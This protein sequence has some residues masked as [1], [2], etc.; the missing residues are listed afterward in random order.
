MTGL[1]LAIAA[2]ALWAQDSGSNSA[3]WL[4]AQGSQ[5]PALEKPIWAQAA[6]A[7]LPAAAPWMQPGGGMNGAVAS[8]KPATIPLEDSWT[9]ER[10]RGDLDLVARARTGLEAEI[11]DLRSR[12]GR[13]LM[14]DP[15]TGAILP[16]HQAEATSIWVRVLDRL[17]S[18]DSVVI[19]Y[20]RFE[21]VQDAEKRTAAFLAAFSA[22]ASWSRLAHEWS[23]AADD[24]ELSRLFDARHPELG[25]KAGFY[26]LIK[27]AA[28][29]PERRETLAEALAYSKTGPIASTLLK[30]GAG[31]AIAFNNVRLDTKGLKPR[32]GTAVPVPS[33]EAA[34]RPGNVAGAFTAAEL[35]ASRPKPKPVEE[36][37]F[38][39]PV[40]TQ[41]SF[42]SISP[43]SQP[44]TSVIGSTAAV[45]PPPESTLHRIVR[46]LV[47]PA[48][49]TIPVALI[50]PEQLASLNDRLEPGDI[51]LW[52]RER[53]L[54]EPGLGGWWSGA[55]LYVGTP[56]ERETQTK[57]TDLDGRIN[58]AAPD[59]YWKGL[60]PDGGYP[61]R[62][63]LA[64]PGGVRFASLERGAAADSLV[65]LRARRPAAA[66]RE[67]ALRAFTAVGRPY[68]GAYDAADPSSLYSAELV[69]WAY[70]RTPLILEPRGADEVGP[71]SPNDVARTYDSQ[72]G[73]SK[74]SLDV[75]RF[76]D[77]K[78]G[79]RRALKRDPEDFRLSW[80][81]PR[82][83]FEDKAQAKAENPG[84]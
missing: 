23:R 52:R 61:R 16:D 29:A 54:D 27:R 25:T 35:E 63:V 37:N 7:A 36:L 10:L 17:I 43:F 6:A 38:A 65:A 5:S 76:L 42:A 64:A 74:V 69:L 67:A 82:W 18:L 15:K 75:V 83:R 32:A 33:F 84:D 55:G 71:P 70:A 47:E 46:M 66:R 19:R 53:H 80:K 2:T 68:D 49:G 44:W 14:K 31:G 59:A 41:A 57:G 28:S 60:Q 45:E 48:T 34:T 79:E 77:G 24:P 11:R 1:V 72:F 9:W 26:S 13:L 56:E 40:W 58:T 78:E 39:A 50:V 8:T 73:T 81:R 30:I 51:L 62:V 20:G 22:Y 12:R 21:E 4:N 3:P